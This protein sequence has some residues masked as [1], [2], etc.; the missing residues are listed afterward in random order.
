MED[1]KQAVKEQPELATAS[2]KAEKDVFA[3]FDFEG[4][5][6]DIN[7]MFKAG[8]YFGHQKARRN[9]KMDR[10]IYTTRNGINIIDLQ[11]TV[12]RLNEAMEFARKTVASGQE[13]VFVGSKKQAKEIVRSAAV[14]SGEPYVIERWLG[15][16]FTNLS[17]ILKR[18]RFLKEGQEKMEKGE[19][20]KYTKFEQM[21]MRE[22]LEK[23][24]EKMGGI[25]NMSKL[26]GAVFVTGVNE[27]KLAIKEA[28][29]MGIPIIGLVD[30]NVNPEDVDYPIPAN[31][32]AV[33][34]L[35][36][37]VAYITKAVL[38]GKKTVPKEAQK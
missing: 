3:G 21:K 18:T 10:Y 1:K 5:E 28:K 34:A 30:T 22:E 25:K 29:K 33:S 19:M 24:E 11:Q 27:D 8:V 38:E 31:E 2:K 32:D 37:M 7:A 13:I 12:E 20:G 35:K 14:I 36:L 16:T 17:A 26:P 23:L 4:L 9:P 6:V 15:G